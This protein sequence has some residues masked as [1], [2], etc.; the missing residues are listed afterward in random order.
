[1]TVSKGHKMSI[2][3]ATQEF[4]N[5]FN[6]KLQIINDSFNPTDHLNQAVKFIYGNYNIFERTYLVEKA[7]ILR[8]IPFIQDLIY[9]K[10]S[11]DGITELIKDE[12]KKIIADYSMLEEHTFLID[13]SD[14]YTLNTI[15]KFEHL[16]KDILEDEY[17][18][19]HKQLRQDA[20][21]LAK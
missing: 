8:Y 5:M 11:D 18:N 7:N 2:N 9:G 16:N 19:Y 14:K 1:K 6:L 3:D 13:R 15:K 20:I 12:D 4:N 17:H 10:I 21:I